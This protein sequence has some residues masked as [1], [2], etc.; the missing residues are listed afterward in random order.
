MHKRK[1]FNFES[2]ILD[3]LTIEKEGYPPVQYSNGSAKFIWATCRYCGEPHRLR[4]C[5]FYRSGSACHKEC[6]IEEQKQQVSPFAD[7]K[8]RKKAEETN[9]KKYGVKHAASN[10]KI[11]SKISKTKKTE[12]SKNKT[13]QTNLQ[14][15]GVENVFQNPEIKNKIAATNKKRYGYKSPIQNQSIMDKIQKTNLN[16]FGF[17][18]PMQNDVVKEKAVATSMDRYNKPNPMQNAK[19]AKQTSISLKTTIKNNVSGNYNLIN[20][21]RGKSFWSM[22]KKEDITLLEI[23]DYFNINYGS[24]T[25]HLVQD[26]FKNKY[27]SIYSFPTQQKQKELINCIKKMGIRDNQI[28]IN[29]RKVIS[30]LELDIYIPHLNVAIEFNGSYWHSEAILSS[31]E[32]RNKHIHKTKLCR[33]KGIFLLHIFENNWHQKKQQLLNYIKSK[34]GLNQNRIAARKCTIDHTNAKDFI[35]TN[36]IQG[37]GRGTI[38]YF[39]LRYDGKIIGSMTAS[40]HHRQKDANVILNR[41]CFC[42]DTTI[43]GGGRRLFKYFELWAREQN[44]KNIISWSDNSWTDGNIYP[45]LGFKK[46]HAYGPDYF[47]WDI[48][49]KK[50]FSKQSKQK[51]KIGCPKDMTEHEY[52]M[53]MG[54]YRIWDCGKIRWIYDL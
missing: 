41:L 51:S 4:K 14:K 6:R 37:Y 38:K 9:L 28:I 16:K 10:P 43:Q 12:F 52:C 30:P 29:T 19:I 35:D 54:L 11:R 21:L 22:L 26:E 13:K 40:L 49:S 44:Y 23:C 48:K 24:L 1:I 27:Y 25:A 34:L 36:H 45:I 32:A 42:S 17:I 5:F 3:H 53:Q 47:Y 15:Y 18:N 2:V 50:Y 39:N 20:L 7:K 33:D 31:I 8:V 46:E